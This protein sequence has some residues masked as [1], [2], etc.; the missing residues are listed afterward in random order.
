[1]FSNLMNYFTFY[2][3]F[4]GRVYIQVKKSTNIGNHNYIRGNLSFVDAS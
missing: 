3:N 2:Q 1:M 4:I